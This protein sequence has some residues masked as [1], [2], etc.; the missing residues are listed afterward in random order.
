MVE[1]EEQ[2]GMA[3]LEQAPYGVIWGKEV[4]YFR[5]VPAKE[6]LA[7][8]S[9]VSRVSTVLR[10]DVTVGVIQS[11]NVTHHGFLRP[12]EWTALLDGAAYVLGTGDPLLG[13]SAVEAVLRGSVY[14]D[15]VFPTPR[16]CQQ[17]EPS[18]CTVASQHAALAAMA[19]SE[20]VCQYSQGV[21]EEA[22][23]CVEKALRR[24]RW[25][26][27]PP[28]EVVRE[29]SMEACVTRLQGILLKVI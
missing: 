9:R 17:G 1:G 23:A 29:Y 4:S 18:G 2:G 5:S 27:A 22:R 28:K 16:V 19:P 12:R 13:P 26:R 14:I 11:T 21:V 7:A 24:A 8:V 25:G 20:W 3:D 15:P 6:L 10:A